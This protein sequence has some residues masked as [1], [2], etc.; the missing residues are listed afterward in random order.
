MQLPGFRVTLCCLACIIFLSVTCHGQT[1]KSDYLSL[2]KQA[3]NEGW[4]EYP[5]VIE[6]WKKTAK[7][8]ELWGYDAPG[9]P[10]Y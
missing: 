8:S 5:R 2:I 1:L 9:Q 6:N 3:A 4:K 7:P 10:V